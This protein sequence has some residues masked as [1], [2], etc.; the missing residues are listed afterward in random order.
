GDTQIR[1]E[2]FQVGPQPAVADQPEPGAGDARDGADRGVERLARLEAT[3][4][5]DEKYAFGRVMGRAGNRHWRDD[6][7]EV[8]N[9]DRGLCP[10]ELAASLGDARHVADQQV[11]IV[12]M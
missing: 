2:L 6:R 10:A 7:G 4:G 3:A 11:A 1:S 5:R 8:G 12:E 9:R